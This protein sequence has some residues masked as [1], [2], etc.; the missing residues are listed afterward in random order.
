MIRHIENIIKA[1]IALLLFLFFYHFAKDLTAYTKKASE[2][3][4]RIGSLSNEIFTLKTNIQESKEFYEEN[5]KIIDSTKITDEDLK[6]ISEAIFK[7]ITDKKLGFFTLK[8]MNFKRNP[9]VI[10]IYILNG[11]LK[12]EVDSLFSLEDAKN[13]VNGE[14][15]KSIKKINELNKDKFEIIPITVYINKNEYFYEFN[16]LKKYILQ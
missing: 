10:N 1:I 16:I 9:K 2:Y 7:N 15:E 11:A 3:D 8:D 5:Q 12:L 14:V 6:L 4:K 13:L